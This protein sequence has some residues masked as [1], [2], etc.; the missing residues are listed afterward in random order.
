[1][2][3]VRATETMARIAGL[4]VERVQIER[5]DI[6]GALIE[7]RRRAAIPT[8]YVEVSAVQPPEE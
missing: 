2:P 6:S 5:L 7:A 3:A 4:M 8:E 1:M